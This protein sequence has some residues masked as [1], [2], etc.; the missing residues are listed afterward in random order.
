EIPS[1]PR[2]SLRDAVLQDDSNS[3]RIDDGI[4]IV[5]IV[6]IDFS[7]HG[8]Y[9]EAIAIISDSPDDAFQKVFRPG[10]IRIPEAQRIQRCDRPCSHC[11]NITHDPADSCGR[12]LVWFD[13]G[14]MIMTLDLKRHRK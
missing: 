11:K 7:G 14:R 10:V 3:H 5:T 9:S 8:R 6:K 1:S 4:I 12:P 2:G 13:C